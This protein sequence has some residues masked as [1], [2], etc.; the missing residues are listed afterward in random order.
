[1][2]ARTNLQLIFMGIFQVAELYGVVQE[3]LLSVDSS[4]IIPGGHFAVFNAMAFDR[5]SFSPKRPNQGQFA[6]FF[7]LLSLL[8]DR[9]SFS[10]SLEANQ[11]LKYARHPPLSKRLRSPIRSFARRHGAPRPPLPS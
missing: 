3:S 9:W 10:V 8:T 2:W 1:M 7:P 6:A 5:S 4:P 11:K